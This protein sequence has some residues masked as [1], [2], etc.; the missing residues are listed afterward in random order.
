MHF[1]R[2]GARQLRHGAIQVSSQHLQETAENE[3]LEELG[4]IADA[5]RFKTKAVQTNTKLLYAQQK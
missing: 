4:L 2:S 1:A 3:F 5:K